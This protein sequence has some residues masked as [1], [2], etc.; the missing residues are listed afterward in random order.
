M[1]NLSLLTDF[2]ARVIRALGFGA[3]MPAAEGL[4]DYSHLPKSIPNK[5]SPK[6]APL[7]ASEKA[8]LKQGGARGLKASAASPEGLKNRTEM[9]LQVIAECRSIA[10]QTL[11]LKDV[12]RL[13]RL[14]EDVV[15]QESNST[16]PR[17]LALML[18]DYTP[19]FFGWQFSDSGRLPHLAELLSSAEATHRPFTLTRFML[20]PTADLDNLSPREWLLKGY[21][22]GSVK[23]LAMFMTQT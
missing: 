18:E 20:T 5:T 13:L 3:C 17:L 9:S 19:V 1:E 7:S 23:N 10:A 15:T 22:W 21:E 6:A 8:V 2:E 14:P 16:P 11:S 4:V 12:S